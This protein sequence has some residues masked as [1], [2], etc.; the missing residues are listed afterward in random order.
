MKT[1]VTLDIPE[2]GL[3]LL[4][5]AGFD[6]TVGDSASPF[7]Y[8]EL[9]KLCGDFE[10]LLASSKDKIDRSFLEKNAHLRAIST[11]SAGF[12]HIDIA[13]ASAL[14][15]PVGH[16]PQAMNRATSDIAFGL[17]IAVSRNFF[18]MHK[19]IEAGNWGSFRPKANLG[20]ELYGKTLGIFGLGAIGYEM[21]RKCKAAYGMTIIYCNRSNNEKAKKE[22]GAMKVSVEELLQKSDVLSVHSNLTEE[23]RYIFNYEA[24]SQMKP[25]AIFINTS[26]GKVHEENGLIRALQEGEIWGAGLDVTDPEPMEKNNPLLQMPNVCILPH[27]GSATVEARDEM[28]RLA[29]ENLIRFHFSGD[30]LYCVNP[31]VLKK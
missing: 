5:E 25:S 27:I 3:S 18:Q 9:T 19:R 29:A 4:R 8:D 31:Q 30:M 26:R 15:I 21:A 6:L 20:Q 17:M 11:F 1:L 7:S 23:T 2:K 13:A 10:F 16:A 12:D 22:L 14:N 24:F 28:S